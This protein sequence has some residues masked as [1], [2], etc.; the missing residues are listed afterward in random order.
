MLEGQGHEIKAN[1]SS[2]STEPSLLTCCYELIKRIPQIDPHWGHYPESAFSLC[3]YLSLTEHLHL[4][5]ATSMK[6]KALR[7]SKPLTHVV[8]MFLWPTH[9]PQQLSKEQIICAYYTHCCLFQGCGKIIKL[10][11]HKPS[12]FSCWPVGD[13]LHLEVYSIK[14]WA[15]AFFHANKS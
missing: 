12:D 6:K 8:E 2:I 11:Y 10:K 9:L 7:A 5:L 14:S 1:L 4:S 15:F 13:T 3:F